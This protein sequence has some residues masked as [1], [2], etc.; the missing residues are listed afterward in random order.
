MPSLAQDREDIVKVPVAIPRSGE[1]LRP[2]P[3]IRSWKNAGNGFSVVEIHYTA[4]PDRRGEWRYVASPKYG[5][6][7]SWRWRKEQEIDWSAKSG[8]LIF[9]NFDQDVHVPSIAFDPPAHWP[10]WIMLDPG[11][12]NPTSMLWVAVDI[13]TEPNAWGYRPVHVYK[14]FYRRRHSS[15]A[16]AWIAHEMSSPADRNGTPQMEKIEEIIVDPGAKQEHQSAAAPEK[17]DDSAETVFSKFSEA[18]LDIGWDVPIVTG[19]NHKSE[20]L[21]EMVQRFANYYV[22]FEGIPLYDENDEFRDPTD[23]E[24]LEGAYLA[25]P[26]LFIHPTCIHTIEECRKYVWAEWASGEV[27]TRRNEHEKPIDK[28]DHSITNIIRFM[29][30]LRKLRG[31]TGDELAEGLTDLESFQSRFKMRKVKTADDVAMEAH[32][33]AAARHRKRA[34]KRRAV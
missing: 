26:T 28:D 23:D 16:V 4:D 3:G 19:N 29:N 18:I 7:K 24:I 8:K 21:V 15:E 25:E 5:G 2:M 1:M 33:G 9:V 30:E 32:K 6:L 17:V 12:T 20:S 11:W 27:R 34:A 14:E 22:S 10:R 31:D 13:D